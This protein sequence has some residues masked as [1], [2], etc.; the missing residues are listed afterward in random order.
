MFEELNPFVVQVVQITFFGYCFTLISQ[1]EPRHME[2]L[3]VLVRGWWWEE[4][5]SFLSKRL[6][7]STVISWVSSCTGE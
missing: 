1:V 6:C 4:K 2:A 3:E 5:G 7:L